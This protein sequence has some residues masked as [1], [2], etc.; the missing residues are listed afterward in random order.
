MSPANAWQ[1]VIGDRQ[2]IELAIVAQHKASG[3]GEIS[4]ALDKRKA[5]LQRESE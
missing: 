1:F 5:L 3:P 2:D 4:R